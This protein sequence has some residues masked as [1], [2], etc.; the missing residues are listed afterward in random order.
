MTIAARDYHAH[1][2]KVVGQCQK[3]QPLSDNDA[4][5]PSDILQ[6]AACRRDR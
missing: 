2:S 4:N 5:P 3:K 1:V 6:V